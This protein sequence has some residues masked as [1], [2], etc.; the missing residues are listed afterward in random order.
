MQLRSARL[1]LHAREITF[2]HPF[3]RTD[4]TLIA[5]KEAELFLSNEHLKFNATAQVDTRR[6]GAGVFGLGGSASDVF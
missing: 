2:K 6:F 5:A 4:I 3:S 1:E